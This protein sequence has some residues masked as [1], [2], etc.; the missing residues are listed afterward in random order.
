VKWGIKTD[1]HFPANFQDREEFV[2][3]VKAVDREMKRIE[4]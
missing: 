1:C 3:M 4:K 2:K